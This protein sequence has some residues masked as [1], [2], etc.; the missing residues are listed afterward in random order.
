M[1]TAV[2]SLSIIFTLFIFG[3]LFLSVTPKPVHA[4]TI[5][6]AVSGTTVT[7][8]TD[9]S[10]GSYVVIVDTDCPAMLSPT[11]PFD[12]GPIAI[13]A[14][15][16]VWSGA[17]AGNYCAKVVQA[18]SGATLSTVTNFTVGA[19]AT[20]T[21]IPA[22]TGDLDCT[23]KTTFATRQEW[24]NYSTWI[25]A[26]CHGYADSNTFGLSQVGSTVDAI[27]VAVVGFSSLQEERNPTLANT[28]ALAGVSKIITIAYKEPPFSGVQYLAG[29]FQKLNP[30]QP[31][32][33]QGI[34]Y[35][36]LEPVQI[37]WEAMRNIAY[38]GFVIAFVIIGFMIM[39][40]SHI[41]PQA[42]ATVQDSLPRIVVALILVTFSYAIAGLMIDIMFLFLNVAIAALPGTDAGKN[43]V[44]E[45]SILGV[46][47]AGWGSTFKEAF[48]SIN[49]MFDAVLKLPRFVDW[50]IGGLGAIIVGIAMLFVMIK[51][52]ISLLIAYAT[53]LILTIFSPFF[54]LFQS[55]PG[56]NGAQSW[57][58]QMASNI[59]VFPAVALMIILAGYLAGIGAW[60]FDDTALIGSGDTQG[61]IAK[62]PLL[63]GDI[64]ADAL[65][66]LAGIAILMMTPG[67]ADLVKNAIGAKSQGGGA[68]GAAAAGA[69]GAGAGVALAGPRAAG[70]AA[71]GQAGKVAEKRFGE[72]RVGGWLN[73]AKGTGPGSTSSGG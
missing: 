70:G 57:F 9:P 1:K 40:R 18:L 47:A 28:G 19:V 67:A 36:T 24:W 71:A 25:H 4:A 34:G 27:G 63:A 13:D 50:I 20:P 68:M 60:G 3:L 23:E 15:T 31:A 30:V 44:F 62:F 41:S 54:F 43:I 56:N 29:Q 66:A 53:I 37:A 32:Y 73:K 52:L 42:V 35:D 11:R 12:S 14:T 48:S 72:S 59:A 61:N 6:A 2:K 8:T 58:K 7:F 17:A 69:I 22:V 49:E 16:T 65:G 46:I 21:P 38:I 26:M 55:L 51:I 64:P 39:F 45:K 10:T 5:S 33:A